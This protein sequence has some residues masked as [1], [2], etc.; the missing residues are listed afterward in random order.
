MKP[1]DD[2]QAKIDAAPYGA[3][4]SLAKGTYFLSS[5]LS[6]TRPVLLTSAEGLD[7]VFIEPADSAVQIRLLTIS[8]DF[9]NVSGL[10]F[11]NATGG[12][13]TVRG[14]TLENCRVTD[15]DFSSCASLPNGVGVYARRGYVNRCRFDNLK[16]INNNRDMKVIYL[17]SDI[18]TSTSPN[19]G[20]YALIDNS[21]VTGCMAKNGSTWKGTLIYGNRGGVSHAGVIRNS[22]FADNT[23]ATAFWCISQGCYVR[24][25][26][27]S[28]TGAFSSG[29][30]DA[31]NLANI[32][33]NCIVGNDVGTN[34]IT[35]DPCLKAGFRLKSSSPC[36]GQALVNEYS[37]GLL[38]LAGNPRVRAAGGTAAGVQDIGCYQWQMP[39]GMTIVIR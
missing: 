5:G 16:D 15:T 17:L 24:N 39:D 12:A 1:T 32:L 35:G 22:T 26:I 2:L 10:T 34:C 33:N 37:E 18:P 19:A 36:I 11:R 29:M 30:S 6:V 20:N 3:T 14:G 31:N 27:F 7:T 28:N 21:L 25:S 9:A 8:N 38:D 23:F 4:L 13:V